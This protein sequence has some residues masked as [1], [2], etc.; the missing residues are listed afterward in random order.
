MLSGDRPSALRAIF[1]MMYADKVGGRSVVGYVGPG[2]KYYLTLRRPTGRI[3]GGNKVIES[4]LVTRKHMR[5][6]RNTKKR[7]P[8]IKNKNRKSRIKKR[9]PKNSR[10]RR[11]R[12][13]SSRNK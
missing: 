10:R 8:K 4:K 3:G 9:A 11:R 13:S 6:K 2:G 7:G 1:M 12:K 5:K